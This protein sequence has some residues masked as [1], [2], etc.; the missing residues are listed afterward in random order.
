MVECP[1]LGILWKEIRV[2]EYNYREEYRKHQLG[3]SILLE[4]VDLER[5][6]KFQHFTSWLRCEDFNICFQQA[7]KKSFEGSPMHII[8]MKIFAFKAVAKAWAHT[9]GNPDHESRIVATKLH[10]QMQ[11][12]CARLKGQLKEFQVK[13][14][15]D[16]RQR[17]HI[18]WFTGR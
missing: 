12:E 3:W 5:G 10:I 4:L 16:W 2:K 18:S 15:L 17:T 13:E 9:R 14:T 11:E 1:G 7:W 8:F 6:L